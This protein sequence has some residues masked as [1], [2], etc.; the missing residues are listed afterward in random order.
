MTY[1]QFFTVRV[2]VGILLAVVVLWGLWAVLS[3]FEKD[4]PAHVVMLEEDEHLLGLDE[5]DEPLR[6]PPY[7]G[8]TPNR[9]TP[10]VHT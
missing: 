4:E 10:R 1:R 6:A 8:Y 7:T 5:A 9:R 2:V 3:I